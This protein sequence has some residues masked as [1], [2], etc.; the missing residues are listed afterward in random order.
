MSRSASS[1]LRPASKHAGTRHAT[2]TTTCTGIPDACGVCGRYKPDVK[3]SRNCLRSDEGT[4]D[5]EN[6]GDYL[7]RLLPKEAEGVSVE[8]EGRN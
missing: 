8:T 5:Y 4:K 7:R 6:G 3:V 2:Q 1:A